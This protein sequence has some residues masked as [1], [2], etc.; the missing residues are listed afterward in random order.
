MGRKRN[1]RDVKPWEKIHDCLTEILS[2][3]RYRKTNRAHIKA[4]YFGTAKKLRRDCIRIL[5]LIETM[6]P[7][8][9]YGLSSEDRWT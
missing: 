5:N 3:M 4:V 7:E 8:L 1:P 6:N 2:D 9:K